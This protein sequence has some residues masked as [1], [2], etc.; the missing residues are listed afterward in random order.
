M[1]TTEKTATEKIRVKKFSGLTIALI[2]LCV[3][4]I[5]TTIGAITYYQ[6]RLSSLQSQLTTVKNQ[7]SSDNSTIGLQESKV[8]I[9]DQTVSQTTSSY[10]TWT[11]SASNAG[12]VVVQVLGSTVPGTRVEALYSSHGLN[13]NQSYTGSQAISDG[14]SAIFPI[15]PSSSITIGV[16]SGNW[17]SSVPTSVTETVT[18]TYYY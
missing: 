14:G 18:I 4:F 7:L 10:T 5:I 12:Y 2:V 9:N 11:F 16:G 1:A 8:W 17:I 3:V 13:Y 6:P 15:L